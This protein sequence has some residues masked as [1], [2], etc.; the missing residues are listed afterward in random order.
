MI[1]P[2]LWRDTHGGGIAGITGNLTPFKQAMW[3]KIRADYVPSNH[4]AR[5]ACAPPD[6]NKLPLAIQAAAAQNNRL[7]TSTIFCLATGHCFDAELF[8]AIPPSSG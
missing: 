8:R 2:Y 5:I 1:S 7:I 6:G 3:G 4:P